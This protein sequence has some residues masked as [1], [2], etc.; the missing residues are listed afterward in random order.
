MKRVFITGIDS[1]TG[2][3]LV[4]T[5]EAA[6]Y[7]CWGLCTSPQQN[8]RILL[9]N[10]SDK[11]SLTKALETAKP[12]FIIHLAAKTFV[13]DESERS[14]MDVNLFGTQN[15]LEAIDDAGIVPEKVLLCSSAN[16]YGNANEDPITENCI[17][18]PV[19]HYAISKLAMEH[20]ALNRARDYP[21]ILSRPFNYTGP[22]QDLKFL[23]PKI[24]DHFQ[25]GE[26]S[27]EL[28]NINVSRDFS[29]V[30]TVT[31]AYLGLL[32]S[33]EINSDR[34]VNIC[35]GK[36][37]SLSQIIQMLEVI[38]GHQIEVRVNKAFVRKNEIA[39]LRGDNSKLL[40]YV[41]ILK[42]Y[43]FEDTLKDMYFA[44]ENK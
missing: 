42:T 24:V 22:G 27:I 30:R 15:L 43:N 17:P 36:A 35:S 18:A 13:G 20:M 34:I 16:I 37:L 4:S 7:E 39:I 12:D 28:G 8:D 29:D 14:F 40:K 1:F 25:R 11:H 3:H 6:G 9:G 33:P 5:F 21:I 23:V 41:K 38:S 2:N 31:S 10:L 26:S 32:E 19:N 44:S